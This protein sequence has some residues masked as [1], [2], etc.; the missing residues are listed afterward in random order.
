MR[1][2]RPTCNIKALMIKL[3]LAKD[4]ALGKLELFRFLPKIWTK[5]VPRKKPKKVH[6]RCFLVMAPKSRG[7]LSDFAVF[8]TCRCR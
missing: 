1:N 4:P 6:E 2:I 3:E 5:N 8:L 7:K